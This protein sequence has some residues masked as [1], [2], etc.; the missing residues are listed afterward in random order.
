MFFFYVGSLLQTFTDS[1]L[2]RTESSQHT[3]T[4]HHITGGEICHSDMNG[5]RD[6]ADDRHSSIQ[7]GR[8]TGDKDDYKRSISG[9]RHGRMGKIVSCMWI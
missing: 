2:Q 1:S 4:S 8:M 3:E 5:V 9:N 6:V 7:D